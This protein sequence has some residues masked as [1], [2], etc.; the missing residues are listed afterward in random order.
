[1]G[2]MADFMI[3]QAWDDDVDYI[4]VLNKP[5]SGKKSKGYVRMHQMK[6]GR[7]IPIS[8]MENTH[9]ENYVNLCIERMLNVKQSALYEVGDTAD[10]FFQELNGVQKMSK[11]DAIALISAIMYGLEPYFTELVIRGNN[12]YI[13]NV[14]ERIE[15]ILGRKKINEIGRN[16][17]K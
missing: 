12:S 17:L 15:T 4:E 10:M 3:E 11:S 1:M 14:S 6:G 5:S 13:I 16:L 8:A 2:D 7:Q 9:I